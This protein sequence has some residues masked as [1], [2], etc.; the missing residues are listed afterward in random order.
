MD[1][2]GGTMSKEWPH[3]IR[4]TVSVVYD[5]APEAQESIAR[6]RGDGWLVTV[7]NAPD[8]YVMPEPIKDEGGDDAERRG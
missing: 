8:D 1:S 2:E 6:M 4:G 3:G 5:P 7:W